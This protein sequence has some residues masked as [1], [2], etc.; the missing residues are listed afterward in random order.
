LLGFRFY[1]GERFIGCPPTTATA[2]ICF[3]MSLIRAT[4][5]AMCVRLHDRQFHTVFEAQPADVLGESQADGQ[6][7]QFETR[8]RNDLLLNSRAS[9]I[10]VPRSDAVTCIRRGGIA[11]GRCSGGKKE[12]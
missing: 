10:Y 5:H 7:F 2:S 11:G 9:T 3:A 12:R 1:F 6:R 4:E 8:I